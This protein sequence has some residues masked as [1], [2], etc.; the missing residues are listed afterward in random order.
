M[1]NYLKIGIISGL[2]AGIIAGLVNSFIS[3]PITFRLG[4]PDPYLLHR[5]IPPLFTTIVTNEIINNLIW[6]I[7][8]G[9]IYATAYRV[10][11]GKGILKGLAF[12]LFG[13]LIYQ[14][15]FAIILAPMYMIYLDFLVFQIFFGPLNW[16][17]YG[18]VI[19]ALYEFLRNRYVTEEP[20][21]IEYSM[22]GGVLPG[23]IAGAISGLATFF[24]IFLS[25]YTGLW[26][27]FPRELIDFSFIMSQL[28][29]QIM[30]HLL[31]GLYIGA[32]FPKVY[33]LIPGKGI[34]K[35]LVYGI[36]VIFLL[37]ELRLGIMSIS[38]GEWPTPMVTITTGGVAAIVFGLVLG[39]LYRK[40]PE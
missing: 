13:Y 30:I 24:T 1:K 40:P 29:T 21:V 34:T 11:P 19:G 25:V 23:A 12:G 28:G 22:S 14:I 10:I 15:Y 39:L 6:G 20:K 17:A 4:F 7:I 8:L 31:S 18:L 32:V 33:N 37:A 2:I 35:G 38:F 9:V 36:T 5:A 27:I 26:P 16:I 3:I